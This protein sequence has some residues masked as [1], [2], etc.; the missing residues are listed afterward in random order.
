MALEA[1]LIRSAAPALDVRRS[2]VGRR[3]SRASGAALAE[4]GPIGLLVIMG[5][6]GGLEPHAASGQIVVA[7]ELRARGEEV[8]SCDAAG[9]LAGALDGA[10]V[11]VRRGV[12]ASVPRPA[13]GGERA[14][15]REEL[16]ALA[17]DMES[18]WLARAT[19]AQAVGVVRVLGDAPQ[20]GLWRPW[21]GAQRLLAARNALRQAAAALGGFFAGT[22]APRGVQDALGLCASPPHDGGTR[23]PGTN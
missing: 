12:V 4:A 10:G 20:D 15:L 8:L 16:G 22:Q 2:G 19:N 3:R 21:E 9:L 1:R 11:E 13:L 5:F 23:V 14:R 6:A 17:A 18:L 7:D